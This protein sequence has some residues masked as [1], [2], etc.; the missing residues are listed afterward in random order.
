MSEC[1]HEF[2]D[3]GYEGSGYHCK[4]CFGSKVVLELEETI[5]AHE[6]T[7]EK[8]ANKMFCLIGID[9]MTNRVEIIASMSDQYLFKSRLKMIEE[10]NCE[11][12]IV[13][14]EK[15]KAAWGNLVESYRDLI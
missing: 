14:K 11:P 3:I 8:L 12:Y 15:A 1:K 4:K 7:I 10:E 13:D 2:T 6:A 5:K 9:P